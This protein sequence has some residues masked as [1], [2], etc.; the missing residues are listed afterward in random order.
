MQNP[1]VQA[2]ITPRF[3][4]TCTPELLKGLGDLAQ[5]FDLP[6]Q[7]HICEQ[8]D[9]VTYTLGLFPDH[10]DCSSIFETHGLIS[11]K[12]CVYKCGCV[13]VCVCVCVCMCVCL[14]VCAWMS[15]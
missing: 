15:G 13:C 3:S 2:V 7:S 4:P 5:E 6:I 9:E 14:H 1:R 12:V 11:D 10:S 8:Q